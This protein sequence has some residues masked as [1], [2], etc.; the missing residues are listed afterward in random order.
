MEMLDIGEIDRVRRG[1]R[2]YSKRRGY[3]AAFACE[4][5]VAFGEYNTTDRKSH[6]NCSSRYSFGGDEFQ[7]Q[8]PIAVCERGNNNERSLY[9]QH[10]RLGMGFK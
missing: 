5:P 3:A 9:M 1:E 6:R 8:I 10:P 4:C 2:V 7:L